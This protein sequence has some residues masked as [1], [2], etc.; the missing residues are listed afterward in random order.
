MFKVKY[1]CT[2]CSLRKGTAI[3]VVVLSVFC[4]QFCQVMTTADEGSLV[5]F[6]ETRFT[7][8]NGASIRGRHVCDRI[9]DCPNDEDELG[10]DRPCGSNEFQC[11]GHETK[12]CIP[13]SFR[14][15][16]KIDCYDKTDEADCTYWQIDY[17]RSEPVSIMIVLEDETFNITCS[18]YGEP[19]PEITWYRDDKPV[20]SKCTSTR[21]KRNGVLSC[22]NSELADEGLYTCKGINRKKFTVYAR[23]S[24]PGT[25]VKVESLPMAK[26]NI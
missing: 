25:R 16:G 15:D 2:W 14:C 23:V 1:C 18:V 12:A 7:C 19:I 9:G 11:N 4:M 3:F 10:C 24:S 8:E 22:P 6:V 13:I 26:H 20:P 17:E 21:I 5:M